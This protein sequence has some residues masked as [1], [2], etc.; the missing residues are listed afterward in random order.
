MKWLPLSQSTAKEIL[1]QSFIKA[2][3]HFR[4]LKSRAL[5]L[6]YFLSCLNKSSAVNTLH[7]ENR[8]CSKHCSG[9]RPLVGII[10]ERKLLGLPRTKEYAAME[11]AA[12]ETNS[13]DDLRHRNLCCQRNGNVGK[14]VE[15]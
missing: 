1:A 15:C 10:R 7:L 8:V 5:I 3:T 9:A 14:P 2:I 6:I 12:S 11:D 13:S 4:L